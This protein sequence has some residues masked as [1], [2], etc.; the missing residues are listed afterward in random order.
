MMTMLYDDLHGS[1]YADGG[2]DHGDD[3]GGH[4][5]CSLNDREWQ[6]GALPLHSSLVHLRVDYV[7][8]VQTGW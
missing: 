6:L 8:A 4:V 2:N 5:A 7:M 1:G 3:D